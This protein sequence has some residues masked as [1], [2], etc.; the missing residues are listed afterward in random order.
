[1]FI[2]M[3]Y[4]GPDGHCLGLFF[5]FTIFSHNKRKRQF[6]RLFTQWNFLKFLS[7]SYEYLSG[8]YKHILTDFYSGSVLDLLMGAEVT[9]WKHRKPTQAELTLYWKWKTGRHRGCNRNMT[10]ILA[11]VSFT[12]YFSVYSK[13]PSL[14]IQGLLLMKS[15]SFSKSI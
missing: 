10:V 14:I 13:Y 11:I 8:P 4:R 2:R 15:N 6:G 5:V 1:M 3:C 7:R 9:L 12:V